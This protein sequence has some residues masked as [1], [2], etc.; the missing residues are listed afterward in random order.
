FITGSA[1]R[2]SKA[3]SSEPKA[4]TGQGGYPRRRE[5][6]NRRSSG[7]S[8]LACR[9][10]PH[11]RRRTTSTAESTC[12]GGRNA[13]RGSERPTVR[14]NLRAAPEAYLRATARCST[15]SAA[16]SLLPGASSVRSSADE[17][18]YG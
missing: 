9:P 17:I 11:R 15:R 18:P 10:S 1:H 14:L 16:T 6:G 5:S 2:L 3:A 4:A 7:R 13:R 12:G 8:F